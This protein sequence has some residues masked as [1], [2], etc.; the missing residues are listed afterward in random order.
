MLIGFVIARFRLGSSEKLAKEEV[1]WVL[2]PSRLIKV[3][4]PGPSLYLIYVL[5]CY[6]HVWR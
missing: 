3:A 6:T 2:L 5:K 1:D 4:A